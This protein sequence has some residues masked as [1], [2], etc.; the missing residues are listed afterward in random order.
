MLYDSLKLIHVLSIVVWIGGMVFTLF[1][2]RP[3]LAALA[4]PQRVALMHEVLG[5]FFKA[6][7]IVSTLAVGSG[8]WMVG[9][10]AKVAVQSGGTFAWPLAWMV[11]TALGVLMYLIFMHIRFALYKRLQRAVAASDWP[12][13]GHALEQIRIWVTVNLALGIAV[14][15]AAF[16]LR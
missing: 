4:P 6:V 9:R 11:M 2:L 12:A 5:R 16:L 1:F 7:L 3:S 10:V 8:L 14:M 13:G 15:A